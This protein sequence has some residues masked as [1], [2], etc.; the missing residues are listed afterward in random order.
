M[1]FA[2]AGA[3]VVATDVASG[4]T[5]NEN[6]EELEKVRLDWKGLVDGGVVMH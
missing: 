1:A 6:E 3:D 5:R 2:R 4:G